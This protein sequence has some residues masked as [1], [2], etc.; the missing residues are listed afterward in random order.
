[1]S[2]SLD[3]LRSRHVSSLPQSIFDA[4]QLGRKASWRNVGRVNESTGLEELVW[5]VY[6]HLRPNNLRQL[7][8]LTLNKQLVPTWYSAG[9]GQNHGERCAGLDVWSPKGMVLAVEMSCRSDG[10]E[11]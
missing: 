8:T 1:M 4:G 11:V 7:Y 5:G 2:R 10:N 9:P 6:Q 3:S